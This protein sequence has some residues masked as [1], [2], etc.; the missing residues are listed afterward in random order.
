MY[1]KFSQVI[2]WNMADTLVRKI[3]TK[4][5]IIFYYISTTQFSYFYNYDK[6]VDY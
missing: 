4:N 3:Y 6:L 1:I 2:F 5:E